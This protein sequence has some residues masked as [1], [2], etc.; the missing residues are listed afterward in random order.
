MSTASD[1]Q[2]SAGQRDQILCRK[3]SCANADRIEKWNHRILA[4]DFL[5]LGSAAWVTLQRGYRG[6]RYVARNPTSN[7]LAE[8]MVFCCNCLRMWLHVFAVWTKAWHE[9]GWAFQACA[10]AKFRASFPFADWIGFSVSSCGAIL[11]RIPCYS[12]CYNYAHTQHTVAIS[13]N[14][15]SS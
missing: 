11:H 10:E 8:I 2:L 3:Q 14:L 4:E 15:V 9:H 7:S 1:L 13:W 6:Y 12:K 5:K